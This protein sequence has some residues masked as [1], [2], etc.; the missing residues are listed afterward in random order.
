[1]IIALQTNRYLKF[2]KSIGYSWE[3][4]FEVMPE[5]NQQFQSDLNDVY[6]KGITFSSN[7]NRAIMTRNGIRRAFSSSYISPT[8]KL[9]IRLVVKWR[10]KNHC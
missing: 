9:T 6:T 2:K 3:T 1:M 7:E 10:T 4:L 8:Q 5:L